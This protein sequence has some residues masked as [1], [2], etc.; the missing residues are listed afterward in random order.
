MKVPVS[1]RFKG[2]TCAYCAREKAT[3]DDHVFAREFFTLADRHNL[4]KAPACKG[5][6][7]AKGKFE[8][9]LTA[10]LPFAGRHSQAV[11][12]LQSGVPGR[13]ANNRKLK[14]E[15]LG[16]MKPAWLK[17][18]GGLYRQTSIIDFDSDKLI[19]LLKFVGR[20]LAWH[21]WKLYLRPGDDVSVM[22]MPDMGSAYFATMTS[23]WRNAQ[24]VVENLGNGTVQYVGVQAP[25]PPELTVWT[26]W[27]YGGLVLSDDRPKT[28]GQH[29]S[30]SMWWVITGPPELNDTISRLK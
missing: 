22:L 17:E 6:N 18:D 3:T 14:R 9:Y 26:I 19:G 20:G 1:K 11:A 8:H 5:C 7:S 10:V 23:S 12:N 30:C 16:S 24:R 15:L 13:L 29:E 27:M 21:H 25:D 28:D 4:P 2:K